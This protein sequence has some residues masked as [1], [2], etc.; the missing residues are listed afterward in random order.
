MAFRLALASRMASLVCGAPG[1]DVPIAL[2]A[3]RAWEMRAASF[4]RSSAMEEGEGCC[5]GT[6]EDIMGTEGERGVL[7]REGEGE[8]FMPLVRIRGVVG[9]GVP[10]TVV[11]EFGMMEGVPFGFVE[12]TLGG[13]TGFVD[14]W[15]TR[16]VL[17]FG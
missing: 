7:V 4:A 1:T 15:D 12:G 8:D 16:S 5:S 3:T 10:L 6:G 13:A 2:R 11:G 9:R 17:S 14:F